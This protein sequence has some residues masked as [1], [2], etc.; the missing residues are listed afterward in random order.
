MTSPGAASVP[1]AGGRGD[2]A[3]LPDLEQLR[4]ALRPPDLPLPEPRTVLD[5]AHRV[6]D[7]TH[8]EQL[9]RACALADEFIRAPAPIEDRLAL[10]RARLVA[11]AHMAQ[12][13]A[14]QEAAFDLIAALREAGFGAQADATA[15]L[16]IER[17][18]EVARGRRR[19]HHAQVSPALM[20]VVRALE[21]TTPGPTPR[22]HLDPRSLV[23]LLRAALAALPEVRAQ[24]LGDQEPV[25][26]LRLAQALEAAGDLP[27]ATTQALDVLELLEGRAPDP[28]RLAVSAH[29][30]LARTL[31][32]THP[33]EAV[34]HALEA[35]AVLH[36]VDDPPL[37]V[38][39]VTD[40]LNSLVHAG[41]EDQAAF[42]AGRLLSLQRTLRRDGLRTRPLL[43]V[44]AQRIRA[45]RFEAARV[46]L[47]QARRIARELRDRH[48]LLEVARLEAVIHERTGDAPASLRALQAVASHARWL[49]DDL[50]TPAARR[51]PLM[52]A[53][54]DA[55]ALVMRRAM[56]LG[57]WA[58]VRAAAAG[59]ERRARSD[60]SPPPLAPEL[61]WDHRVDARIAVLLVTGTALHRGEAGVTVADY[62]AA[63]RSAMLAIDEVPAG[64]DDRA[65]YWAAYLDD[66][67][68]AMLAARGAR[69]AALRAARR[70]RHLW[71]DLGDADGVARME[72]LIAELAS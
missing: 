9:R 7:L 15:E 64:H 26:R 48:A 31:A 30:V 11:R 55:Q 28:L 70:A 14:I 41:A 63:R 20:T 39:L 13:P 24:L 44:A 35:L 27:A 46:P 43:A 62:Q 2:Q 54:L 32:S 36:E 45:Q 8:A 65:R 50:E 22:P 33:V 3:M 52:R 68:A 40:L 5:A 29:A 17:S 19:G 67:H 49:A 6:T 58:A 69:P 16:H 34:H 57:Q 25:L 42:T 10:L 53:E 21:H 51:G 12:V 72:E 60:G 59:I 18:P 47:D 37:R 56:D 4:T 66:R 1:Q 23:R 61:L 71:Q 38:G